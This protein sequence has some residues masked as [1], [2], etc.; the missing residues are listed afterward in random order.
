MNRISI[1]PLAAIC[2]CLY[3]T[4]G[5]G[6][7][8][9]ALTS[10]FRPEILNSSVYTMQKLQRFRVSYPSDWN[11]TYDNESTSIIKSPNHDAILTISVTNLSPKT[12]YTLNQYSEQEIKK[13]NSV[14]TGRDERF[15]VAIIESIPYLLSG[16]NAYKI[17]YL[18]ETQF[19]NDSAATIGVPSESRHIVA[20]TVT[21]NRIYRISCIT[22][23]SQY[24][25]YANIFTD[26]LNS[27]ELLQ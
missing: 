4:I 18:N 22:N 16:N 10:V 9:E 12:K 25:N 27:F 13:I 19:N 11:I 1:P 6:M 7:T 24:S 21:G 8:L 17:V 3:L 5:N 23:E 2:I 20:W 15:R 26:I 14:T